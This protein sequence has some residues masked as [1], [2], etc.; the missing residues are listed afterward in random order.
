MF[1]KPFLV[2]FV[3]FF[4]LNCQNHTLFFGPF[5]SDFADKWPDKKINGLKTKFF[6]AIPV[7]VKAYT[8]RTLS[9]IVSSG[10]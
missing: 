9:K 1:L 3:T 2:V 7:F 5:T 8:K 10:F 6:L 4:Y